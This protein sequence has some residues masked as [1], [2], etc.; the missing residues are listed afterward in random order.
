MWITWVG[1]IHLHEPLKVKNFLQLETRDTAKEQ[2]KAI[3][4]V[5]RGQSFY[6]LWDGEGHVMEGALCQDQK[7]PLE[8]KDGP[9]LTAIKEAQSYNHKEVDLINRTCLKAEMKTRCSLNK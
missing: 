7:E 3:L 5:R 1:P 8:A 6:C 4:S 9:Q 2:V